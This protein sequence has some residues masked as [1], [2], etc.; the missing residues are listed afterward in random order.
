MKAK[1][2]VGP[3]AD[4]R[5]ATNWMKKGSA[6]QQQTYGLR[7]TSFG[8]GAHPLYARRACRRACPRLLIAGVAA[9]AAPDAAAAAASVVHYLRR[10]SV[11][12][13]C[14]GAP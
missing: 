3:S 8:E 5:R 7:T 4:F 10:P 12:Q 2:Q 6:K 1:V 14:L 13:A 9:A 11:E